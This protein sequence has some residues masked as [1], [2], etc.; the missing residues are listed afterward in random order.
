MNNYIDITVSI[1]SKMIVYE[2]DPPVTITPFK[3]I[4]K[5]DSCNISELQLSTHTGTH[6]DTPFHF[7]QNGKTLDDVSLDSLIGPVRIISAMGLKAISR[8]DIETFDLEGCKRVIFKTEHSLK[9]A[10]S[11]K[12]NK[13]Y[14]YLEMDA[15]GYLIQK[16]IKLVGIDSF[17]IEKFES[18]DCMCH[19]ILLGGNV[20]ILEF[21]DLRNVEP[22]D[23][24][25]ICLPLKIARADG[26]P[27]RAILKPLNS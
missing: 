5:G 12:F 23:Y 3:S 6:I 25:L 16:G 2:G 27:V 14:V 22:G 1:T 18:P 13:N 26:A 15:C 24:E 17:S 19:K 8:K 20:I 11:S 4:K 21:L 7:F 10:R 9:W